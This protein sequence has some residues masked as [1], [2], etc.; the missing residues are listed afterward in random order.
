LIEAV[1]NGY[2]RY[3]NSQKYLKISVILT[4]AGS[5]FAGFL[6]GIKFFSSSCAFNEP[7][8]YFLG[9]PACYFGFGMFFMMFIATSF[10]FFKKT[11]RNWPAKVNTIISGLGI[12]FAGYFTV[13]EI[14]NFTRAGIPNYT[15]I[16]PTCA[17][18]LVFYIIIFIISIKKSL[19]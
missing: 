3:M 4:L 1:N 8:P 6:S 12:L 11:N 17:Y 9:Y 7:C 19:L 15:L 13:Q 5:L 2:N 16:L 10:A 18:G 14:V